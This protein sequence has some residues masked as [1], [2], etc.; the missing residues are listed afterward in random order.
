[1]HHLVDLWQVL[2]VDRLEGDLDEAA[3]V[4][5]QGLLA[6]LPVA[7]VG[8][9]DPDHLQDRLEDRRPDVGLGGQT[10][11]DDRAPWSDVLGGLLEGLLADGHQDDG[12]GS[13]AVLGGV[14]D[15]LDHVA[16]FG[17]VDEGL[18]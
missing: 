14:L 4:K 12:V 1:M 7:D 17:K 9:L 5:V 15:V 8:S 10:D 16:G 18:L 6:V 11:D 3:G 2:E 13:Q